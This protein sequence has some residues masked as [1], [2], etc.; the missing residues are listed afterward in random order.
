MDPEAYDKTPISSTL[1]GGTNTSLLVFLQDACLDHQYIRSRDTSHIVERPE[2][3]RAVKVGLAATVS[4]LEDSTS[5]S[6]R[7]PTEEATSH[8]AKSADPDDLIA[9]LD[10]MKLDTKTEIPLQIIQS[11]ATVDILSDPAVKFVHGDVDGDV[12]LENLTEWVA[13]S[14]DKIANDKSEIPANLPQNDLYRES[15]LTFR[16]IASSMTT[17][18]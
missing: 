2:R 10:R 4:R 18:K 13:A 3:V 8:L 11:S 15:S 16:V 5:S 1:P 9:A 7:Q 12:Y 14:H 6:P 17:I